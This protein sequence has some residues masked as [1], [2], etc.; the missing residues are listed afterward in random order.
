MKVFDAPVSDNVDVMCS[1]PVV[2]WNIITNGL[3]HLFIF[4]REPVTAHET[5]GFQSRSERFD[6]AKIIYSFGYI[7]NRFGFDISIAVLPTC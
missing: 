6:I 7:N 2:R 3:Q 5:F 4:F 1:H